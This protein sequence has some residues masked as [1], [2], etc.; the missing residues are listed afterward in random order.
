MIII[1]VVV[2]LGPANPVVPMLAM[3]TTSENSA[4]I[5]WIVSRV[6]YTPENFTIYYGENSSDLS[7]SID[8]GISEGIKDE[9][10]LSDINASYSLTISGLSSAK[11]YYYQVVSTNT[12]NRT[13]SEISSFMTNEAG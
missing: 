2:F 7:N 3:P 5:E 8:G 1:V 11:K 12:V 10:F 6:A 9:S 4:T 13:E